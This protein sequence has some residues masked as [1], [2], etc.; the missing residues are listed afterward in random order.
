[1]N[2]K[3]LSHSKKLITAVCAVSLFLIS[4]SFVYADSSES[5]A[6]IS[7]T[8]KP[9]EYELPY[10]GLLP[11]HPLY[12]LR[13]VRDTMQ[14]I[15]TSNPL[16]KAEFHLL[17]ADKSVSAS[18]LLSEKQDTLQLAGATAV[19]AQ[20]HFEKALDFLGNA[21]TQGL[22]VNELARKMH[23]ANEKH[24][25]TLL[26]LENGAEKHREEFT[27]AVQKAQSVEKKVKAFLPE[28]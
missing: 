19:E 21:K 26:L 13:A 14:N 18:V 22:E 8:P 9:V 20:V 24:Q 17:Q 15:F 5:A 10:P 25:E 16:K 27:K 1:M 6:L 4:A 3:S 7:P 23:L 2:Q 28:E 12:F 11:D